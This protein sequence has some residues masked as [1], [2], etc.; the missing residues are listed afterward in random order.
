MHAFIVF[1]VPLAS[2]WLSIKSHSSCLKLGTILTFGASLLF[3]SP[4]FTQQSQ[5]KLSSG[6]DGGPKLVISFTPRCRFSSIFFTFGFQTIGTKVMFSTV[7]MRV[8]NL[9]YLFSHW[10]WLVAQ[11]S[12]LISD[13]NTID[14]LTTRTAQITWG[15]W[16]STKRA[17]D[18]TMNRSSVK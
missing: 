10:Y 3:H 4:V 1:I 12:W 7:F 13:S 8:F 9:H 14:S 15:C 6:R 11:S 18:S 17:R 5:L 16:W 2:P